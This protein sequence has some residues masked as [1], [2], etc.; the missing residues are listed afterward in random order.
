MQRQHTVPC[1]HAWYMYDEGGVLSNH[2]E[3]FLTRDSKW[4]HAWQQVADNPVFVYI[5]IYHYNLL[6]LT[7]IWKEDV[8]SFQSIQ[9]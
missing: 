9:I 7:H 1:A 8:H 5:N 2:S 6:P 4:S 3:L